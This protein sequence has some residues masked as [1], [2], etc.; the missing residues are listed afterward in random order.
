MTKERPVLSGLINKGTTEME[1]FQNS[2][3]RPIIKMQHALLIR[4]FQYYLQKRKIDF[5]ALSDQKKR[6]RISSIFK[7]DANHKNIT[8]G[9]IIG[10]FS[11][12]EFEFYTLNSS[13]VNRR[14]LQIITK[15]IQD[16]LEEILS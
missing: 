6:G 3:L 8:L 5:P 16:S 7:T 9:F 15:R 4:S 11:V 10:H 14:I 12:D 2:T 1:E 13:E